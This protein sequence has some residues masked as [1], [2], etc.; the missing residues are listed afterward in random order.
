[1]SG[2]TR[3]DEKCPEGSSE[4]DQGIPEKRPRCFREKTT[5]FPEKD[6]GVSEKRPRCFPEKTAVF[7]EKDRGVSESAPASSPDTPAD[8]LYRGLLKQYWGY[9][10]FRGIQEDIIRSIASGRDTLGLMPTGGGKSVTF[11]VPALAREGMCLVVTPLI[12][13]MKDQVQNLRARGIRALCIHAGMERQ[14]IVTTLENA[15]FGHYKF[16]YVSPERLDTDIFRTKLRRMHI[17]LITVDESHCISQWG[18]DFRPA[19]LKIAEVRALLPGVPVLA[20]TATATPQVVDDIQQKLGFAQPNVFR[21][22]FERQNLAYIVRRTNDKSEELLHILHRVQGSAIVYAR[23]RRRTKDVA[24]LLAAQGI[25]ADYYHAGLD[26]ATKDLRQHRWQTGE[27]RVMVATNAFG[28]GIDKPDVRLVIHI[29]LPDS[30]EAYFQEA[31]RAG[32]DGQKAYAVILYNSA[33]K[34]TLKR[35]I[36]DTFPDPDYIRQVYEHLQYYYQMALGDGLDCVREFN[37]EDFCRKFHHFPVPVDS[38]L[39]ILT[40]A[41]YLEYTD[42]QDNAS[43]LVF[44]IQRDELYRLRGLDNDTDRLIHLLLRSYTGLFTDYAFINED[45]LATRT[46]LTRR[47]VYELLLHLSQIHII[48]Y[49]PRKKIPHIRYTRARVETSQIHLPPDVYDERKKRY[50][51]RI[52]AMLDYA[53]NDTLCRSRLLLRYFGE[54]NEHDCGHCDTCLESRGQQPSPSPE[55]I[56]Q[57]LLQT[58]EKSPMTPAQVSHAIP[59]KQETLADLLHELIEERCVTYENGI[60]NLRRENK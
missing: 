51:A 33:D 6:R 26:D 47:R 42:E 35:R 52:N 45:L 32:R 36:P 30:I 34:A 5:V 9:D 58:L 19:Y 22:S 31:G 54:K 56:R 38:A 49:I 14:E 1:M 3:A 59:I 21:M 43:R 57:T 48:S 25:T 18:Y 53:D 16:L 8:D 23:S 40:L 10:S 60:L 44:T 12:A 11:Q 28:M 37:I 50:E 39:R 7:S 46:G 17:S 55:E 27:S 41:G 4:K 24:E 15:I 13:L 20:L 29:D 2:R